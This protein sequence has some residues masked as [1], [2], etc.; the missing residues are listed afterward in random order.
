MPTADTTH[1]T[2][3]ARLWLATEALLHVRQSFLV[4]AGWWIAAACTL[5]GRLFDVALLRRQ[6]CW[7]HCL[8]IGYGAA[9]R[10]GLLLS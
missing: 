2:A 6:R 10:S 4:P 1:F 5:I 9:R 8:V 7:R 3:Y